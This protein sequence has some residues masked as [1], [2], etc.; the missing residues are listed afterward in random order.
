MQFALQV[1]EGDIEI[2]HGHVGRGVTEE[3]HDGGEIHSG[4]KHLTGIGVSE[5]VRNDA[6]SNARRGGHLVQVSAEVAQQGLLGAGTGQQA[7]VSRQRIERTEEAETLDQFTDEGVYGDHPF[8]LQFA[9]RHMDRPLIHSGGV[10]T[11][12]GKIGR[13]ADAH[14]RVAKQQEYVG[15]EIIAAPQFLLEELILLHGECAGQG[16]RSAGDVLATEQLG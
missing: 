13:F 7:S 8:G 4:A 10:E 1:S 15:A 6:L 9:K 12:E 2:Q 5:L 14:A 3:F 11:I 16:P